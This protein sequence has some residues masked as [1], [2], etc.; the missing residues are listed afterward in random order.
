MNFRE[1]GQTGIQVST[2]GM[3][4]W[5]IVGG[6]NWGDQDKG[7][8]LAALKAA[9]DAGITFFDTAEMYGDGY[10]EQLIAEAL[11]G[12][13]DKIV[14]A[15]KVSPQ[16]FAPVDLREACE[17]SLRN[18]K[19]DYLDLYQLHWPNRNVPI[20]DS[21]NELIK[22]KEEGKIRSYG[23]S[24]FGAADLGESLDANYEISSNQLAYSML[25]RAIEYDI[26]PVCAAHNISILCYSPLLHGLLT[27]KFRSLNEIPENRARTR[28]FNSFVWPQARHGEE[29]VEA[30]MMAVIDGL[31]KISI[32]REGHSMANI[33]LA[34]LLNQKGVTSVIMGGRNADQVR[35]NAEAV[36][37]TLSAEII[38]AL[39]ELSR[40]LKEKM[41]PN[42]DM[43]QAKSRIR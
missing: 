15:S 43:W 9:Y 12:V 2:I 37:T 39:D 8:S 25:F 1:L 23:V 22:L 6:L 14:I 38:A 41:G 40:P 34:W 19:T 42:A 26:A 16:N 24:N 31:R 30:E 27:G 21:M 36:K 18:L 10:S 33:A 5:A 35:R 32:E 7:D 20:D 4:C 13:R 17:R 29:G 3:G 11:S 28:H